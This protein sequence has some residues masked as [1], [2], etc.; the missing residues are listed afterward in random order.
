MTCLVGGGGGNP[1]VQ[2]GLMSKLQQIIQ[3]NRLEAFY[4]PPKLQQLVNR[5]QQLDF[6]CLT[7]ATVLRS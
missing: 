1:A 6:R 2:Q 3:S 4:P 5:L 7:A